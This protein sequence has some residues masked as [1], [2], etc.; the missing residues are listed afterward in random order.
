MNIDKIITDYQLEIEDKRQCN[1]CG[2]IFDYNNGMLN[3]LE[4]LECSDERIEEW[5]E[6]N[7]N[8]MLDAWFCMDCATKYIREIE[9]K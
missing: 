7:P 5:Q 9:S 4:I 3:I 6:K 8:T 1:V 2:K